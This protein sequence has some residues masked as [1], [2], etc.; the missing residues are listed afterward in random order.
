MLP[1]R[2]RDAADG[3][4]DSW[5]ELVASSA[6]GEPAPLDRD[7]VRYVTDVRERYYV[8]HFELQAFAVPVL[9]SGTV[10]SAR[11]YDLRNLSTG[12]AKQIS[13]SDRA[14]GRLVSASGLLGGL[15]NVPPP[16][17]ATLL[18]MLIATGRLH[19]RT[20]ESPPLRREHV[21]A[22][23]IV[24]ETHADGRQRP[25][26]AERPSTILIGASP[27]W[28][29]DAEH[30]LA[31][32]AD[33]PVQRDVAAAIATAPALTAEQAR[34]ARV[35]LA[36]VFTNT[37]AGGPSSDVHLRIIDR[38]PVPVLRLRSARESAAAELLFAYGDHRVTAADDLREFQVSE[39]GGLAVWPRR[40]AFEKHAAARLEKLGFFSLG[41]SFRLPYGDEF[42]WIRVL[43]GFAPQLR[44]D[45]W[46]VEIDEDFPYTILDADGEWESDVFETS[47][48]WFEVDLGIM[49][50]GKRVPLLPIIVDALASNG[51]NAGTDLAALARRTEPIIGRLPNGG[52]VA[53]PA[54]RVARVLATL[55]DL[56]DSDEA[57]TA[58]GR[59]RLSPLQGASLGDLAQ[60]SA[61]NW[62]TP[63]ATRDLLQRLIDAGTV[64]LELPDT[65][66]ATLRAYQ[67]DGVAWLQTLSQ[68]GF[69][70]VLA[71]DMGLG[72]TVQ[73][74]AHV[75]VEKAAGRLDAPVLIVA[76]TSVIPNWR[77]EIARFVPSLRVLSLTGADRLERLDEIDGSD[78]VL[79]TFALLPR[80]AEHLTARTWSIAVLDEAQAIKNPR[81]KAASVAREL[82]ARQRIA[83]TGTPIENH[84]EELW[85]IY[86]FALPQLLGERSR[87]ARLYRT[88]IEKR[89][90]VIRHKALAS[91]LRPFL[92][93][94]TKERV[95][96][97][98]PPKTE[99][100]QRVELAGE[101]RDLYE[102]I[103]LA[104]HKRVR[105][106]VARRGLARSRIVVLDALLKLRQ[107][108]CDPRLLKVPAAAA[109]RESQK[110]EAL[111]EMLESLIEDGRR[112]LLFSQF[113]S[114]LDLIKPELA[115]RRIPF[116][117]LRGDTRD[118]Q[119]PV[120]RFQ[121]GEVPL[122]LISLKAGGTGLNLTAAD[123]VIHYDP[124][125][126]PAVE[127]QAT[128]RAHRIGQTRHV[129]VYKLIAEGT[130]EERILQLQERK[131]VLASNLFEETSNAPLRLDFDEIERLF[132]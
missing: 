85:S 26:L 34:R 22:A 120:Q 79:T 69:G 100:V 92:L 126:N 49:V 60:T 3:A 101:Q 9:K 61:L 116:V 31:G 112:V 119:L 42:G 53:L 4:V 117:E 129:F 13:A 77:S 19:W 70:G 28:Y 114:M 66:K 29:V 36:H 17:L 98:L 54:A 40:A 73:L 35:A 20:I 27:L 12:S 68:H 52:Y 91:R 45:G 88:P 64:P 32:P 128:D 106:E 90:D 118:R 124:W 18:E 5:I 127:R 103:R 115:K 94:R 76:P 24:W 82:S 59:L 102:T 16:I 51:L 109:V 38:N 47:A 99:I 130:V 84:L 65:F 105:D 93:R 87:F 37:G 107:V 48:H 132:V 6:N 21:T 44:A 25:H 125:W 97:E 111:L 56:F 55:V 121:A 110:L 46:R 58:E 50:D 96:S 43:T 78:I 74:L 123:T 30:L 62:C 63:S 39:G 10:G 71:D 41:D 1:E 2:M 67:R 23:G 131:G 33:V 14:I 122:F 104:M 108:C 81:A 95:A 8:P 83:M 86:A 11:P 80:D 75:A 72:K 15:G 113:T 89:G 7:H 57:L